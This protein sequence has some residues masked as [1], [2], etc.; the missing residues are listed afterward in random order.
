MTVSATAARVGTRLVGIVP[1]VRN[2]KCRR[3]KAHRSVGFAAHRGDPTE[4]ELRK[5]IEPTPGAFRPG[6]VPS[7]IGAR[8]LAR[9]LAFIA[10]LAALVLVLSS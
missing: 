8:S 3:R 4:T 5:S 6:T 10:R 7:G 9:G 1:D 2:E